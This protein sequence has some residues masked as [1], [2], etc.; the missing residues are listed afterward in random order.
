MSAPPLTA[1]GLGKAYGDVA[2]VDGVDL[3]LEPGTIHG[4]LGPNGAGK[5]T[6]VRMLATLTTIGTGSAAVD[7]HDVAREGAAVRRRIGV[8]GQQAALDEILSG[9]QN[10]EMFGRLCGLTAAEAR[11]RAG[12]LLGRFGLTEAADRSVSTYSGGMRRRLDIA[13]SLILAPAVLFLDEPTTGLD[14]RARREVWD[15][16]LAAAASGTA[17]LLT[18]QYLDEADQLADLVSVLDHGRIVA[19]GA[20]SELKSRLGADRIVLTLPRGA[21]ETTVARRVG[22]IIG[23]EASVGDGGV[24]TVSAPHGG[25]DLVRVVRALDA[26]GVVPDDV[27]LRRP[28]LDEVFLALTGSAAAPDVH[29]ELMEDPR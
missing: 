10:L 25:A 24:L 8:V 14:P 1:R 16:V 5:T 23:A 28:T 13:T 17:V 6:L 22:E 26:A 9:S 7:G 11:E 19:Q 15:A 21:D 4:L 27:T 12:E 3:D 2:A 18:T 29:T 20:P